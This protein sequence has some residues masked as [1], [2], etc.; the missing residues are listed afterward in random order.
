MAFCGKCGAQIAD[1]TPFCA[2]CGDRAGA[3][4]KV[5][6]VALPPFLGPACYVGG[7]ITGMIIFTW[8]RNA[9]SGSD[10][11]VDFLRFHAAQSIIVFGGLTILFVVIA[12]LSIPVL[13]MAVLAAGFALWFFLM[14]KASQNQMYKLPTAG[15]LAESLVKRMG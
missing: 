13:S 8:L 10:N 5:E 12:S 6:A 2:N 7:W 3:S 14:F 11:R 9:K 15:D 4:S 1:G